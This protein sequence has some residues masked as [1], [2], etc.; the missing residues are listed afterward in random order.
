MKCNNCQV[1]QES[2]DGIIDFYDNVCE[3][4]CEQA[5]Y[6]KILE[7]DSKRYLDFDYSMNY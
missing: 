2:K 3:N 4:C 7:E 6:A 1:E 5:K